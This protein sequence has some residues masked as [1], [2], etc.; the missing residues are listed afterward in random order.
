VL[1]RELSEFLL[2]LSIAIH[3]HGIYPP[4]HPSL[5]PAAI[6]ATDRVTYVLRERG[7]LSLGAAKDQLVM[8]VCDVYDALRTNRPYR[9]PWSAKKVLVYIEE[10]SGTEF[11]GAMAHAFTAMMDQWEPRLS[12]RTKPLR[13]PK[14]PRLRASRLPG[15]PNRSYRCTYCLRRCSRNRLPFSELQQ[16]AYHPPGAV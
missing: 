8:H 13:L 7:T 10:K 11:D 14:I 1:S 6:L 3:Q 5:E 2:E 9:A 4:G 12:T 15:Y 16:K